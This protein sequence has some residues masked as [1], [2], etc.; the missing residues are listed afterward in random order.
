[1]HGCDARACTVHLSEK[2]LR[3]VHGAAQTQ[4]G[5]WP[6]TRSRAEDSLIPQ[7]VIQ[8]PLDALFQMLGQL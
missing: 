1:M 6:L 3:A 2:P 8:H 4:A 7:I 5:W